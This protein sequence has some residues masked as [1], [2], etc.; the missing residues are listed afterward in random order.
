M[1][2]LLLAFSVLLVSFVSQAQVMPKFLEDLPENLLESP[3][4]LTTSFKEKKAEVFMEQVVNDLQKLGLDVVAT[5]NYTGNLMDM[6]NIE[7]QNKQMIT[8]LLKEHGIK[9]I[10]GVNFLTFEFHSWGSPHQPITERW[11]TYS[12]IEEAYITVMNEDQLESTIPEVYMVNSGKYGKV[13]N[14][15][16][17]K[18]QSQFK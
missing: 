4:L 16:E 10:V 8:P 13:K 9:N 15:F 5:Y 18:I 1:K 12:K 2:K 7:N 14:K 6:K 17:E 11:Y 3:V